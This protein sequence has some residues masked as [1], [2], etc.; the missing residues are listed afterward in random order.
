MVSYKAAI[1]RIVEARKKAGMSQAKL[2]EA[3]DQY[4]S[5]VAKVEQLERRLDVLEFIAVA[6]A[7]GLSETDLLKSVAAGLPRHIDV[8]APKRPSSQKSKS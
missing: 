5:W 1:G 6:R 2:A 4:P 7:L 8:S 3:L